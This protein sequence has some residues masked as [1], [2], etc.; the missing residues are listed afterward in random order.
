MKDLKK[1]YKINA[2]EEFGDLEVDCNIG[3]FNVEG[4]ELLSDSE[5]Y[6]KGKFTNSYMEEDKDYLNENPHFS[7]NTENIVYEG[8]EH[9]PYI[10]CNLYT[11]VNKN[12]LRKFRNEEV[13]LQDLLNSEWSDYILE[14]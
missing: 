13:T 4:F 14:S 3:Y 12:I 2:N 6:Y 7:L 9:K 8:K 5:I 1:F 10:K 11:K